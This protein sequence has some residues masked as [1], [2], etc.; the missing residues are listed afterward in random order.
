MGGEEGWKGGRS[1]LVVSLETLSEVQ[2]KIRYNYKFLT[3]HKGI[4]LS[5]E[6]TILSTAYT[7]AELNRTTWRLRKESLCHVT[8]DPANTHTEWA[9]N[10][11][12]VKVTNGAHWPLSADILW[13]NGTTTDSSH[14][15]VRNLFDLQTKVL[16]L[17]CNTRPP[18]PR[19]C[20]RVD[21][22]ERR[23]IINY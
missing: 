17:N 15:H 18:L 1:A 11:Q 12:R 13:G 21:L 19:T 7:D 22:W 3:H 20:Q 9:H 14:L 10:S 23:S 4:C 5:G 16:P 6:C 2:I 8:H